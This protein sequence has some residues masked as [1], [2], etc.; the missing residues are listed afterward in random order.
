MDSVDL[1]GT[2][3]P[4]T[5]YGLLARLMVGQRDVSGGLHN[6]AF[7]QRSLG[8]GFTQASQSPHN[9]H[10]LAKMAPAGAAQSIIKSRADLQCRRP[11]SLQRRLGRCIARQA[12]V[13]LSTVE[14]NRIDQLHGL[15][16]D[17]HAFAFGTHGFDVATQAGKPLNAHQQ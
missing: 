3:L 4:K 2:L 5:H 17:S 12:Q 14:L 7:C 16:D 10:C 15:G 8:C 1:I 11:C 9:A 6:A 13:H